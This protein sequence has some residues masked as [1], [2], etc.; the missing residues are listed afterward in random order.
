VAVDTSVEYTLTAPSGSDGFGEVAVLNN[1]A[2][3]NFVGYLVESSGFDSPNVRPNSTLISE[4]HGAT[5]GHFY[6][7]E[8]PFT[9]TVLMALSSTTA[10]SMA[11]LN[12]LLRASNAML[13]PGTIT[14]T[15]ADG[16][17]RYLNFR[18]EGPVRGPDK[19]NR[20]VLCSF[21]SPDPY[22]YAVTPTTGGAGTCTNAGTA[23]TPPT[24]TLTSP[25]NTITLTNSTTSYVM[26]LLGLSGAGTVT[27]DMG[28]RTVTAT[29]A[30]LNRYSA[31]SFP[32][33]QFWN[34]KPGANTVAVS[35]AT[36]SGSGISWKSAFI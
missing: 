20:Q 30:P 6:H 25:T 13:F 21:V 19:D 15:E 33:S 7:G 36:V 4:G 35:G 5:H 16:I 29:N 3:G 27:V 31:V 9:M 24:F 28:A 18:R 2:S 12:K 17:A 34:L 23:P 22:I 26:T 8:R 11:R 10:L 1:S 32:T 14:W